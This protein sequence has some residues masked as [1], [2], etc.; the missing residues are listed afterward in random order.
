[1]SPTQFPP[2]TATEADLQ[3]IKARIRGG[4]FALFDAVRLITRSSLIGGACGL[5]GGLG[6]AAYILSPA[7]SAPAAFRYPL[8][9]MA[10]VAVGSVVGGG[11]IGLICG[12][13]F[14]LLIIGLIRF[15]R[16]VYVALRY[17]PEE[18]ERQYGDPPPNGR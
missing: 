9:T 11:V 10:A 13:G 5:L 15:F 18:F 3:R 12:Y 2:E 6:Y 7:A 4:R 1:M 17:S 16:P 14:A 8:D